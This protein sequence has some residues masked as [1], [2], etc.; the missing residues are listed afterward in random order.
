MSKRNHYNN[1]AR[2]YSNDERKQHFSSLA[3]GMSSMHDRAN[4][5]MLK[6]S[7]MFKRA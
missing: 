7:I 2:Q 1:D 3:S 6:T 4:S 5:T